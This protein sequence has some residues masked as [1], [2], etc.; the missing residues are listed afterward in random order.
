M[1]PVALLTCLAVAMSPAARSLLA[2]GISQDTL[3]D[4][5]LLFTLP[6]VNGGFQGGNQYLPGFMLSM[7]FRHG[8]PASPL[9]LRNL[10]EAVRRGEV[11]GV[12]TYPSGK[13]TPIAYGVVRHRGT[14]DIYMKS[15]LGYFLWE[16]AVLRDDEVNF[17]IDWWY[18]PPARSVDV[19]AVEIAERLLADSLNWHKHDDRECEDDRA[20]DR[21]SLFCALKHASLETMGEY[22]H[23]NTAMNTV[24]FVIDELVPDHGFEHTLM[25]Y[26]NAESTTHQ[27]ILQLLAGAKERLQRA[28]AARE[29]QAAQWNR[30]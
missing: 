19:A 27:D 22:N 20:N 28:I 11:T 2:Q 14:E 3:P 4:N 21:W 18:T 7:D 29:S 6:R 24:R 10:M 12:L 15:T 17:V 16:S 25:D 13:T 26:N 8:I 23:H 30:T 1:K 5:H 9:D